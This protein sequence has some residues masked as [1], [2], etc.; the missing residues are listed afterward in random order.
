[1]NKFLLAAGLLGM[2]A[3]GNRASAQAWSENFNNGLPGG[4]TL[5]NN[6]GLTP[7]SGVS[8]VDKAWVPRIK[9]D[10]NGDPIPGDSVML[11]TSWYTPAGVSDDWIITPAFNVAN[12]G[13]I[14]KWE[15]KAY[16]ASYADGY[17]VLVSTT[18][19]SITDFTTTVLTVPAA[20]TSY[21]IK[22]ASLASFV[23]QT[24]HVAFRNNSNDKYLLAI[25]NVNALVPN[26]NDIDLTGITP[27]TGSPT[28]Y[29]KTGGSLSLGGTVF[30]N[31]ITPVTTYKVHYQ[32]GGGPVTTDVITGV[33]IAPFTS[34]NFTTPTAFNIPST[35]GD[36]QLDMWVELTG[37]AD[38]TNDSAKTTV[39]GVSFLPN[40]RTFIE[41][42]TG[43]WCGWCP[44]GSVY[45]D[46]LYHTYKSS[47]SLVAVHNG[48]PM[49][50]ADYDAFIGSKISGYPSVVIDRRE[51]KDPSELIDVYNTEKDYFAFADITLSDVSAPGFG[52][53]IK[54]TVKPAL[55]LSGDYRLA[56][57]LTED[58]V[59]GTD[60]KFAQT[61]YYSAAANNIPL[62]GAG[63]DWQSE[64]NPIAADK[65]YYNFVAR[66]IVP[67]VDGAAGSLPATMTTGNTYDYTFTTTI[68]PG[69]KRDKMRAIVILIRNSDGMVLNSNT[70]DVPL[71]VKDVD[72]GIDNVTVYPNPASDQATL[73]LNLS[74][75]SK[76]NVQVMD[77]MGRVVYTVSDSDLTKGTHSIN[78]PTSGFAT[79]TYSV[80]LQTEKGSVTQLLSVV[81]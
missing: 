60:S 48:D 54:A 15:E 47:F 75:A 4:W 50:L 45:M 16:D 49:V 14:I 68:N 58:D 52:Y 37:D 81:K 80:R 73:K 72:A 23:G 42:G 74:I 56:L 2:V 8:F 3:I 61:N 76:V 18:G 35:M 46:S 79:G 22:Y 53:S 66:A 38:A 17:Q 34:A 69:Y 57:V 62:T 9:T 5:I 31:G 41:E 36:Y 24:I 20:N 65:M 64:S 10:A 63:H 77:A 28:A 1:M 7:N 12:A 11:S 70:I 43:T 40:K 26:N 67:S 27:T 29:G 30:N 55:D 13:M 32:Q 6:D 33:N 39:T 21:T 19:T 44:R 71:G 51:T 78:I 59:H 25:D